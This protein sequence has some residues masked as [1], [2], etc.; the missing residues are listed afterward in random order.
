MRY[1]LTIL[2]LLLV[3]C[4]SFAQKLEYS[5][6]FHGIGDNREFAESAKANSQTILGERFSFELGTTIDEQHQFRAGLSHLLEFGSDLD[7][8][9]PKL[10]AY[11]HFSDKNSEFYFGAFPRMDLIDY[12]LA[13]LTDTL[14][15]YR[16]NVEGMFGKYQ[17]DWGYQTGF[18]DWTGRQTETVHESFLA[19]IAGKIT[20]KSFFLEN[21]LIMYHYAGTLYGDPD[22]H[23]EDNSAVSFFLGSD[24]SDILPI[25]KAS[26]KV[27]TLG[28]FFKERSV[29]EEFLSAWSFVG[30][31]YGEIKHFALRSTFHKGQGHKITMGDRFYDVDSYLR[32]DVYWKFIDS[33]HVQGKF[34]LSMHLVD[35]G[36]LDQSQQLSLIYKFGN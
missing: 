34:N 8:N 14:Q 3:S 18:I 22:F 17:W 9:K 12:P 33:K 7:Y 5:V 32:T 26:I 36:Y 13:M 10:T 6:L 25:Q 27:G 2:L 30:E 11:Y 31:F 15:Y 16:P 24:L 21:Y 4:H 19:G 23:I 29:D 1:Q 20:I 28:S 35:G